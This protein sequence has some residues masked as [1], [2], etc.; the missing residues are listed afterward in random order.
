[1]SELT[2]EALTEA[3]NVQIKAWFMKVFKR[4]V[5]YGYPIED[6]VAVLETYERPVIYYWDVYWQ[7]NKGYYRAEVSNALIRHGKLNGGRQGFGYGDTPDIAL[8]KA[9]LDWYL[10][11]KERK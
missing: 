5:Q 1:M 3:D 7:R 8:M 4:Y 9:A 2:R 6:V 11:I 10:G